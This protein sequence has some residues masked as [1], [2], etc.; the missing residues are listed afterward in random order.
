MG[1]RIGIGVFSNE[2]KKYTLKENCLFKGTSYEPRKG[3]PKSTPRSTPKPT[4][5]STPK[6]NHSR[7]G[8]DEEEKNTNQLGTPECNSG[9]EA[10]D[11]KL[12]DVDLAEGSEIRESLT[13]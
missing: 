3:T 10:L 12:A 4:P 2:Q 13:E 6:K 11:E 5:K 9:G 7:G 8:A 1:K